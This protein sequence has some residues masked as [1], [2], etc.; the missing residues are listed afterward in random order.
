MSLQQEVNAARNVQAPLW[1]LPTVISTG[2]STGGYKQLTPEQTKAQVWASIIHEARGIVWFSQ[3]PDQQNINDCISGDAFADAR[4][5]NTACLR[6]QVAAAGVVNNQIK[7][8]APVLNTQSYKWDF[9]SGIDSMLKVKDGFAYVFAMGRDGSTGSKTF[10]FPAG[11]TGS[12]VEVL[13]ENR[14]IQVQ[15][16]KFTDSFANEYTHHVYKIR[17]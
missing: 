3:S 10:T 4:V 13:N 15:G 14:T 11:V 16:G 9:G 8:L 5:R 17:I 6:D 2:G 12:Q 1:A 7:A